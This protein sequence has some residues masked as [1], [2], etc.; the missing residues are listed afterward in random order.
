MEHQYSDVVQVGDTSNASVSPIVLFVVH[1]HPSASLPAA[2]ISS[3]RAGRAEVHLLPFTYVY[4]RNLLC[5]AVAVS[6]VRS[7]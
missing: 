2:C 5:Q 1:R 4:L 6:F 3:S 7:F